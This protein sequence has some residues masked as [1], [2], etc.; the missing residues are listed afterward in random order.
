MELTEEEFA[1]EWEEYIQSRL[2]FGV[3]IDRDLILAIY[4]MVDSQRTTVSSII[5]GLCGKLRRPK[6]VIGS[7]CNPGKQVE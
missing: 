4:R 6:D 3:D 5:C 2:D 1:D 7:C